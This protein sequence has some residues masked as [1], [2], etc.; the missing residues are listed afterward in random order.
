MLNI[1][2]IH[3][4]QQSLAVFQPYF[5]PKEFQEFNAY[6]DERLAKVQP[7]L[8][9]YGSYNSGKS[10]LLNALYGKEEAKTGDNPETK[11]VHKYSYKNFDI[12]DTPGLHA[13]NIDDIT[14]E[15]QLLKSDIIIFVMSS[16]GGSFENK[17]LYEKIIKVLKDNKPIII[18]VNNKTGDE[19]ENF[20]QIKE[21]IKDNI[22]KEATLKKCQN[23]E[24]IRDIV[25]VN[26]KSAL[27]GKKEKKEVLE[28]KSGIIEFEELLDELLRKSGKDE[29]V[30]SLKIYL[31]NTISKLLDN[32]DSQISDKE[33]KRLQELLSQI[34]KDKVQLSIELR[35]KVNENLR[36]LEGR[37]F[38]DISSRKEQSQIENN[39]STFLATLNENLN[40]SI[41]KAQFSLKEKVEL[42]FDNFGNLELKNKDY[43]YEEKSGNKDFT[44]TLG[45][46]APLLG[47]LK[48]PPALPWIALAQ[49]LLSI[50]SNNNEG[51]NERAR[52]QAQQEEDLAQQAKNISQNI[53]FEIKSKYDKEFFP[54]IEENF[55]EALLKL[56]EDLNAN[57][58]GQE[59]LLKDKEK[60]LKLSTSL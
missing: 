46:I 24:K 57:S 48:F 1:N 3:E 11:E 49:V 2:K 4:V 53:I 51:K 26:A 39:I 59:K 25:L 40:F 52:A 43:S 13:N 41:E 45:T 10:S 18:V 20:P 12:F 32:I 8:M 21:K 6:L 19:K 58:Q 37:I 44:S 5:S 36:I 60:L 14:S 27:K 29:V 55:N 7:T 16:D 42:C 23:L 22:L 35:E 31:Q 15:D 9:I 30:N 28:K 50:F 56:N 34:Q 47:A 17:Y 33:S 38:N 54:K